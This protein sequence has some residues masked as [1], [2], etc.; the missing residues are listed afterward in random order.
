M[1]I[2]QYNL[3]NDR[4]DVSVIIPH[5]NNFEALIRAVNSVLAQTMMPLEI[6]IVDDGSSIVN[7]KKLFLEKFD[8]LIEKKYIIFFESDANKGA[9]FSRNLAVMLAQGKYIAFLDADDIWHYQKIEKQYSIMLTQGLFFSY[10]RYVANISD[11]EKMS[12]FFEK[13][14]FDNSDDKAA[15][16]SRNLFILT[17]PIA[18]PTVMLRKDTFV[19]FDAELERMEDYE[20]WVRYSKNNPIYSF[21]DELSAGFKR[22]VGESGLSQNLRKMHKSL[23]KAL[24][25]LYDTKKISIGFFLLA[26]LIE[27]IKYPLRL[28]RT[29]LYE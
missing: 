28:M 10:H 3:E 29:K 1:S 26:I 11:E 2:E 4:C 15:L 23:I 9:S 13:N 18:T 16:V 5:Y 14:W 8:A 19:S 27:Y 24:Y 6:V 25:K 20:C 17:N 22:S 7:N 21:D 12:D